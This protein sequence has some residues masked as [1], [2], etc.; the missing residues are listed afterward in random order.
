[1]N[2]YRGIKMTSFRATWA[3]G[4]LGGDD[5]RFSS[6]QSDTSL[7]G[8]SGLVHRSVCLFSSQ[9]L[10]QCPVTLLGTRGT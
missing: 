5:L 3:M 2:E 10:G 9:P 8:V 6:P 1:M 4:P 7:Y